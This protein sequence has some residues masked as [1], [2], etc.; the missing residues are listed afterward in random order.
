M[1][2]TK[3]YTGRN[4]DFL[5]FQ[6]TAPRGE[7]SIGLGLGASGGSVTTGVQKLAQ[8]WTVFFLT[9]VGSIPS[10]PG[11]GTN[12]LF[13]LRTGSIQD[14][15]DVQ[16]EFSGAAR[17][18]LEQLR[19]REQTSDLVVPDDEKIRSAALLGF[20]L[21]KGKSTLSLR[22]G[23]LSVAGTKHDIILPVPIPIQ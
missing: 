10:A 2:V 17:D 14:E 18:V 15:S 22:V 3:N 1:K 23:L 5:I 20:T 8:L 7:K 16:T 9:E 21:D 6:G 13:A 11:L 19:A 4:V 12:F